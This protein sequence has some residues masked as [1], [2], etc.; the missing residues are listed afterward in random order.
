MA[1]TAPER[2]R[3]RR[4]I[5]RPLSADSAPSVCAVYMGISFPAR[6]EADRDD[7]GAAVW[8]VRKRSAEIAPAMVS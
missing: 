7:V 5:D 8:R 6:H 3:S 2:R 4:P 1:T